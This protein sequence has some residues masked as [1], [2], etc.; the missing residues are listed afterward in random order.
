MSAEI[1]AFANERWEQIRV[2]VGIAEYDPAIDRTVD[3]VIRRADRMMYEN[4]R[5]RKERGR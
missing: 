5:F 1:C 2:A 3:D 4:K